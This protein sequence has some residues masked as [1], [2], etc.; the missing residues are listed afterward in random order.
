MGGDGWWRWWVV[1]V[2]E[3]EEGRRIVER[4]DR[5]LWKKRGEEEE[6]GDEGKGI[7]GLRSYIREGKCEGKNE[8]SRGYEEGEGSVR[9]R[10][11]L[12]DEV[13]G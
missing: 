5:V 2:V 8:E 10:M 6:E 11:R 1:E 7:I 3:G 4:G 12:A 9:R 13:G